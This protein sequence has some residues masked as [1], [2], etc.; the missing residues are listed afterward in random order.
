L[1]AE[2]VKN[3]ND[4]DNL[5]NKK[6]RTE[7]PFFSDLRCQLILNSGLNFT[8]YDLDSRRMLDVSKHL[9][10]RSG[11]TFDQWLKSEPLSSF[12]TESPVFKHPL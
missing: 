3:P 11:F 6:Q 1:K 2:E 10:Q 9:I 8:L 12:T 5:Q 7:I 4:S